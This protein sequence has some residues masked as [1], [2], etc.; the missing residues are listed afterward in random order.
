M[1]GKASQWTWGGCVLVVMLGGHGIRLEAQTP[2]AHKGI[3]SAHPG[4]SVL[5]NEQVDPASGAVTVMATDL[6]LPGNAGFHLA[7]ARVYSSNVYPN[8][9]GGGSTTFDEDSWAGI[10]WKLHFGRILNPDATGAGET[11]IEMGDGSRHPLYHRFGGGW[12]TSDFWLYDRATHTLRL[13]NGHVYVFGRPVFINAVVGTVRYVT[14]ISDPFNNRLTFGYFDAA[15]PADGVAQ[16][17]QDLGN[18]QVRT[19]TFEYDPTL[20]AL[21]TMRYN[22]RTWQYA[23]QAAGPAGYSVLTTVTP[24]IGPGWQYAYSPSM[25]GELATLTTPSGGWLNYTYGDATRRA[26]ALS[27]LTRVATKRM[28]GGPGITPGTWTYGYGTG[29]NQDTTVVTCACGTTRY[30]FY[31]TGV[32][33]DFAGWSA[34]TLR[35]R[36][37]EDTGIV[38]ERQTFHWA[39][40]EPISSDPVPGVGGVW[41]DDQVYRPLLNSSEV[42]RGTHGWTTTYDY[43]TG[44]G[45]YNDYGRAYQTTA[46]GETIYQKFTTS[47]VFQ[48]GFTPYLLDRIASQ[49]I[50]VQT[51]YG[52]VTPTETS[53]WTYDT[54]TGFL[55]GQSL[56][57]VGAIFEPSSRGNVAA[58]SDGLGHRTTYTYTWGTV[59]DVHSP[60]T[61]VTFTVDS[62]G[63]V[64]SADNHIDT[65]ISYSYDDGFRPKTMSRP[66]LNPVVH[67]Y[68]NVNGRFVRTA[69]D[70][71]Q[72]E[73]QLDGFGR[74]VTSVN[75]SN[76]RSRVERDACGRTTFTSAPYT[77]G[78]G[79]RGTAVRY[80][81]LGQVRFSTDPAGAE[82]QYIY[83]GV[84][85]TRLDAEGRS[86]RFESM[87]FG[88]PGAARLMAVRDAKGVTTTYAYDVFG[89][90]TKVTGPLAGVTRIWA[91]NDRGWPESDTQPESGTTAYVYDAVGNVTT[92]TDANGHITS[93][94]YDAENRLSE[95]DTAGT[96]DDLL[97]NYDGAGRVASLSGGGATTS[98]TYDTHGRLGRRQDSVN[99]LTAASTYLYDANDNLATLTYPSTRVVTYQ[100]DVENRLTSVSQ[101]GTPFAHTVTYDDGGRL[102]SYTTGAVTHSVT[103]DG[104][105]RPRRI[106][107]ASA[108]GAL[109]LTYGYDKVGNVKTITDPR[110]GTSQT[111]EYDVLDRLW[112]ADGSYGHLRWAYDDAG[113]RQ[114]QTHG[115]T[116]TYTYQASTQRLASTSGAVAETFTYDNVGQLTS[117]GRGNYAYSPL[118]KLTGATSPGVLATYVY[119]A[120]GD[121]QA[122][123]VNGQTL[124][125]VR[126][127]A[128]DPLSE[129]VAA[130]G[131]PVW[132]RDV[133]TALGR[134]IGAIRATIAKP[135]VSV[136]AAAATVGE[137]QASMS[138]TVTLATPGGAALA[139]PVT[140]SYQTSP[141]TA[142]VGA[143]Y[144]HT[145][146]TVTFP[147]GAG[148]GAT[149]TVIVPLLADTI[150]EPNETFSFQLTGASGG[151]VVAPG[152]Q[153]IT[154]EDDD[155]APVMAI[156]QP[157]VG[158]TVKTPFALIGWAI[159]SSAPTGTGVD[160]IHVYATPAGG[161]PSFLGAATYGQG[162]PDV[163]ALYGARFTNAGFTFS[164]VLTP[165]AYVLTAYARSSATGVFNATTVNV[166]VAASAA[167]GV[168]AAPSAGAT[169]AQPFVVSGWA[170]D[171]GTGAGT[172]V[173]RV[174]VWAYPN[175]GSG[176]AAVL[177]GDATYGLSRPDVAAFTGPSFTDVGFEREVRGLTPGV[178]QLVA[179][180]R[181]TVT[182]QEFWLPWPVT[183]TVQANPQ[184]WVDAPTPNSVVNQSFAVV[185]WAIDLAT[186]TGTGVSV[187]HVWA[188]PASGSPIFLGVPSY[189]HAR[190]DVG[191]AFGAPFT[192][193]AFSLTASLAPG[194][195]QIVAYAWSTVVNNWAQAQSV[196]V[197]VA[198]S[199]PVLA[200][201]APANNSTSG[202]PLIVGGWSIDLG[203]P[204]GTGI[205]AVHIYAVASGGS[206]AWTFLGAA[207][208]GGARGDVGAYYGAQFTNS[209]YTFS[210][211]ALPPGYYQINVYAHSAVSGQW[212]LASRLV[213]VQ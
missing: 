204:S 161:S 75:R 197:T 134:P 22:G 140:A 14:E 112:A 154:I 110:P 156:E 108:S 79:T 118:G 57:G 83:D 120:A 51:S 135:T 95:R 179:S 206:G 211:G 77:A 184:M 29:P 213:T 96:V 59:Q 133:V 194:T 85:V 102:G 122:K 208:Y 10:G 181:S 46:I 24:P 123:T 90:L 139:C 88:A 74:V 20:K 188:Y 169:I 33:G 201:E 48:Y 160:L 131:S 81:V 137:S 73:S 127:A 114:T 2:F 38:L 52:Q 195:Y 72:T 152:G 39:R 8:Y 130:C 64:K 91:R 190:V 18:G 113:N 31:G 141:G 210:Y 158:A 177:V 205:D 34:G 176:T 37:V 105:D 100:Y 80:D 104:T 63:L 41:A 167:N 54:G 58:S 203:T 78:N 196:T 166:T 98:Y 36:T 107:S 50:K 159:D 175:P 55:T 15:G 193:S 186:A 164:T 172:G 116:T 125:T 101:N 138:V 106:L 12:I 148:T 6:V 71:A 76:V 143:D 68:D 21:T 47:R 202:Q 180:A 28:T 162:R 40:S 4:S 129:F 199:Q 150:N 11:Q 62:D 207:P 121:R 115:A 44:L 66:G 13:P 27:Q 165:G 67:E 155:V 119:D 7:V 70:Q 163:A 157:I 124:Y 56:F 49:S 94:K 84:D 9:S 92:R 89:N 103:Y 146:G 99:G 17:Q 42:F 144:T 200:I 170:L 43:H 151:M 185:G 192:N 65:A 128:G 87:A 45:N 145:S 212:T 35:E 174:Q 198:T 189:G 111:F 117:D 209:S 19:V 82:T 171:Q 23:Q 147:A 168:L 97:V 132:S 3:D 182:G 183:V 191:A 149:V 26:G 69:R 30:T 153:A 187:L 109:D 53:T 16:I 178:Y 136:T 126:S 142:T 60:L 5:P 93:F 1:N 86:T 32:T 61:H 173:D 25:T